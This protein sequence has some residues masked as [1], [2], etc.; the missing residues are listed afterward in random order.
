M[1][2]W[3]RAVAI[4]FASNVRSTTESKNT[5]FA[6]GD[7][8]GFR[9]EPIGLDQRLRPRAKNRL[10]VAGGFPPWHVHGIG[11]EVL[12]GNCVVFGGRHVGGPL[13][14]SRERRCPVLEGT[15]VP[16]ARNLLCP[17]PREAQHDSEHYD[18]RRREQ[19]TRT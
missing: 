4:T 2:A 1:A 16:D 6:G 12:F 17:W 15:L 3:S 7:P 14:Q 5:L 9:R 8:V 13:V 10:P 19:P 11:A 18:G